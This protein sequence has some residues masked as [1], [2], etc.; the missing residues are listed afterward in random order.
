MYELLNLLIFSGAIISIKDDVEHTI[1]HSAVLTNNSKI[2]ETILTNCD[3]TQTNKL[4]QTV[5]HLAAIAENPDTVKQILCLNDSAKLLNIRDQF[6]RS[7]LHYAAEALSPSSTKVIRQLIT[8]GCDTGITDQ[9]NHTARQIANKNPNKQL[10]D[11][12]ME[13]SEKS[14]EKSKFSRTFSQAYRLGRS[15]LVGKKVDEMMG[16]TTRT[17]ESGTSMNS[18]FDK[19]DTRRESGSVGGGA[20]AKRKGVVPIVRSHLDDTTGQIVTA[21]QS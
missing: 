7:A 19:N 21:L 10:I 17:A 6:D 16:Q 9:Y 4:N 18:S 12:L 3:I 8:A 15:D 14:S 20:G 13:V 5:L 11:A 1:L 2:L